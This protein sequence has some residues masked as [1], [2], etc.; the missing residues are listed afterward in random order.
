MKEY[1][2]FKAEP[3]PTEKPRAVLDAARAAA[4]EGRYPEA[5]EGYEWFFDHALD[6]DPA[7]YYGV[8]LSYC[9]SEWSQLGSTYPP[10]QQRLE[11]RRDEALQLLTSTREPARF[12]DF[13]ALCSVLDEKSALPLKTFADLHVRDPALASSIVTFIWH[14]LVDA[15]MWDVAAAYLTDHEADYQLALQKFEQAMRIC[16][17]NPNFGGEEFAEQ[18]RGWC[19]ADLRDLWLV[20]MYS[21]R[22]SDAENVKRLALGDVRL[23]EHPT[24]LERA[25]AAK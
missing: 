15:Q 19:I 22:S 10:A 14:D 2:V 25:F 23:Q 1:P 5:L 16:D 8:R 20:L 18:I 11:W 9:L 6:G 12:H 21:N 17:E 24:I 7:S 3:E 13:I 4:R